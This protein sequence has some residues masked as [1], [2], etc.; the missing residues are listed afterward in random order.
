MN[1]V[2]FEGLKSRNSDSALELPKMAI[3]RILTGVRRER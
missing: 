1:P 2:I 3:Y